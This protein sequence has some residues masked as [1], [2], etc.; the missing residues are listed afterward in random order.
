MGCKTKRN[1]GF[2]FCRQDADTRNEH[3]DDVVSRR[4]TPGWCFTD[5]LLDEVKGKMQ[6][7]IK[8]HLQE[9]EREPVRM[10]GGSGRSRTRF[11][12]EANP[13]RGGVGRM[14]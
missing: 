8:G 10:F 7:R 12:D 5:R 9:G 13:H 4:D 11:T 6:E 2:Y 1:S 3:Q 14:R